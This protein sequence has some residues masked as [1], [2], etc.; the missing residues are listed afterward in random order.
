MFTDSNGNLK[1]HNHGP[2]F[3]KK[4]DDCER[5]QELKNGASAKTI[6][7]RN[8]RNDDL[9]R[10]EEIRNHNCQ[11]NNCGIVCTAFDW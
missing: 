6:N 2:A 10:A 7:I 1:G 11:K 8:R 5:C 9:Q 4:F 3:G